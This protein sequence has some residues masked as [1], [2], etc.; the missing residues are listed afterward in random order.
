DQKLH[1]LSQCLEQDLCD[2][3]VI[4]KA[5]A[6]SPGQIFYGDVLRHYAGRNEKE[7][8]KG[9]GLTVAYRTKDAIY[10]VTLD[11]RH[12][13][14]HLTD[15]TF[16]CDTKRNLQQAYQNGNYIYIVDSHYDII[17]HPNYWHVMGIDTKSGKKATPMKNDAD[18]GT[19]PINIAAYQQG[20][21]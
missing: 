21:L 9:A 13:Q 4:E 20:K 12:L 11:Y 19:P 16:P 15:S 18:E 2:H 17:V 10:T 3:A 5:L 14:D 1:P 6:A 8:T 7:S